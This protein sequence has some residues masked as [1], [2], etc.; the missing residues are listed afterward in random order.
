[1]KKSRL[2]S[3]FVILVIYILASIL[4]IIIFN[5][6]KYELWLNLL[7]AD[8]L[9]TI[10]VFI[11]SL[12]FKN[13]S[14][15][16]PYWSVQPIVIVIGFCFTIEVEV[17][18]L[19]AIIAICL[20]GIRLTV[21]WAY[22]FKNLEHQDWRYTKLKK[23]SKKFY[24]FVNLFGI[25]L[26]PT[27]IVYGCVLPV[28]YLMFSNSKSNIFTVIFFILACL[29][30]IMQGIADIQMHKF[31]KNK[32]SVFIRNGLWKYSR[33]P[34]YL[35][36][37]MMWWSIGLLVVLTLNDKFYLLIG[38][39]LNTLLFLFISIP[40]AEKNQKSRKPGFDNYKKE[41]RM[42]LPIKKL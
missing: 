9:A 25:H 37:I 38:A 41:T 6:L 3:Y 18:S 24:P 2:F 35:G 28:V 15:Y 26:V 29:S 32:P 8:V 36:E 34:N 10:F 27:L 23:D 20:W 42:L 5:N 7:I 13:A 40:M 22:T 30:F 39:F 16:D 11:F 4:G 17:Y 31:R 19:L 12:V 1:M 14:V 21:N 33:H